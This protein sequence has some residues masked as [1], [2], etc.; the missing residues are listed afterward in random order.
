MTTTAASP[1]RANNSDVNGKVLLIVPP[2][3]ALQTPSLGVSQLKANIQAIGLEAEVVYL[4]ML[5]AERIGPNLYEWMAATGPYLVGDFVFSRIAHER[6]DGDVE[7]YVEKVVQNSAIENELPRRLGKSSAEALEDLI[8]AADDFVKND[9]I[10]EIRDR[11]PWMVGFSSTFQA[12]GSSIAIIR[13]L[14]KHHPEILTVIGGANCETEM[15][16]ELMA[17]YPEIDFVGRGECDKTFT[18]LLQDLQAGNGGAGIEGFLTRAE[19]PTTTPSPP[20]HGPDLDANPH[21]DFEDYFAQLDKVSFKE[22]LRPGLAME[23]SRG[24]WWGAK[25]HCTFC[26]FNREGMVFRAKSPERALDELKSQIDRY[27]LDLMEMT[28]NILDMN[29]FKTV[30]PQLSETPIASMFWETKAN[31]TEQQVRLLQRAGVKWIQPGI[32]SLSDKSLKLMRK[33]SSQLQN[34]QLLKTCTESGI[35]ITWNWLFGFP[36]EDEGEMDH[37]DHVV[38]TIHHLQPPSAAPVIYMERFAPYQMTPE[39]WGLDPIRPAEAYHHVYPFP[40]DS[41]MRLAFFYESDYFKVKEEGVA[42]KRLQAIV[43]DWNKF[44]ARSHLMAVPRR[45]SLLLL[46]TRPCATK[47]M[48]KL[49]G[50]ERKIYDFI[51][52]IRGLK[53]VQRAFDSEPAERVEEILESFVRDYLALKSNGRYLGVATDPRL[54]YRDFPKL[55][56]GGTVLPAP[57]KPVTRAQRLARLANPAAMLQ[58]ARGLKRKLMHRAVLGLSRKLAQPAPT[59]TSFGKAPAPKATASD[60]S[61][62]G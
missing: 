42:H 5:F 28:D 53:E 27:G 31:L 51:H 38:K 62:T 54:G 61:M 8:A 24:C 26:A 20:L 58:R 15:G 30:L 52:S 21:P 3:Q 50:L 14:K 29:Y 10:R 47:F 48:R 9:A 4:N 32:E 6:T 46:D 44:N 2:F 12:N 41:L 55:F 35:R 25:S 13:E 60:A 57:G 16:L 37:L 18:V 39:E 59:P 23:T 34:V 45:D 49:T 17:Q 56:P 40:E 36:G 19:G 43:A 22:Q 33:G 7:R 1:T 11:D